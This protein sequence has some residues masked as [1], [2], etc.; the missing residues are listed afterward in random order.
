MSIDTRLFALD[1]LER[2][3]EFFE[4]FQRLPTRKSWPHYFL[5]GHAV[6]LAL[7]A[8]LASRG[9]TAEEVRKYGHKLERLLN[10]AVTH[11]LETDTVA[12]WTLTLLDEAHR[13]FW[14]RYPMQKGGTVHDVEIFEPHAA[15]LLDSVSKAIHGE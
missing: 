10:A 14:A 3:E 4:A 12:P 1:A 7:K 11:G 8:F 2:A 6:E 9:M 5:L 13:N 15:R